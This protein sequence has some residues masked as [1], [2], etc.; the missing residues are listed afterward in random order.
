MVEYMV[1]RAIVE[2]RAA[3]SVQAAF[4][5]ASDAI[6][7][8]YPG[9]QPVQVDQSGGPMDLHAPA[10][11]PAPPPAPPASA[12]SSP[13]PSAPPPKQSCFVGLCG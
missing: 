12:P 4:A 2:G 5:Y 3:Q 10:E 11:K 6:A 7:R 1:H 13:P 8:D 9:R